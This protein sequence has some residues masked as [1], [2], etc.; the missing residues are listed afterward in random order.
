MT[1]QQPLTP[2][3]QSVLEFVKA[4]I[5]AQ[6]PPTLKEIA[7]FV[8]GNI[9]NPAAGNCHIQALIA[10]GYITRDKHSRTIRIVGQVRPE[11]PITPDWLVGCGAI[12]ESG[13]FSDTYLFGTVQREWVCRVN[14]ARWTLTCTWWINET[15]IP[16]P[17]CPRNMGEVWQLLDRLGIDWKTVGGT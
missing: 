14:I 16:E 15:N 4:R 3:Q 11:D 13:G 1:S 17:L 8:G 6:F 10:K 12:H 7:A 5:M 2:K 9:A